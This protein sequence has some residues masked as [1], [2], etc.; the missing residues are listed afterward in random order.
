M[1]K[2]SCRAKFRKDVADRIASK[3]N[4]LWQLNGQFLK[5]LQTSALLETVH[6]AIGLTNAPT[7]TTLGQTCGRLFITWL[8]GDDLPT[9]DLVTDGL[10]TSLQT[11]W[12]LAD[13][14]RYLFYISQM[15]ENNAVLQNE[16]LSAIGKVLKFL[17][18]N[19]F[20]VLYPIGMLSEIGLVLRVVFTQWLTSTNE[21]NNESGRK[22]RVKPNIYP[23]Y[24]K[25][26]IVFFFVFIVGYGY[27]T[28]YLY[29]LSQRKKQRF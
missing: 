2:H 29:M 28:V 3:R 7:A 22:R 23:L 13:I 25:I 20:L 11:S 12:A 4:S 6:S 26:L 1:E 27:P 17:R 16:K 21:E 15:W 8:I 19:G 14:I 10:M 5:K 24:K 18:Y 9:N